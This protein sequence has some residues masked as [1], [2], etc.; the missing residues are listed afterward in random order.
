[1]NFG[2]ELRFE[3]RVW[4]SDDEFVFVL[5]MKECLL[6]DTSAD[7]KPGVR[8]MKSSDLCCCL[9][10]NACVCLTGEGVLFRCEQ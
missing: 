10:L 6:S 3:Q 4:S 1:M 5:V 7:V 2:T 8:S 9:S